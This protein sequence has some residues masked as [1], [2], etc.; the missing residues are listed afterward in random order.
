VP[1][2]TGQARRQSGPLSCEGSTEAN[3]TAAGSERSNGKG[4]HPGILPGTLPGG[5]PLDP[6]DPGEGRRKVT[7][8]VQVQRET[9][10]GREGV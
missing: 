8:R 9:I 2:Q 10:Q 3:A 1:R 4:R 6:L 5:I 7:Q